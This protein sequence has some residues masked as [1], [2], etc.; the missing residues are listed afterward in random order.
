MRLRGADL[1]H[2]VGHTGGLRERAEPDAVD[3]RRKGL[4]ALDDGLN[5]VALPGA[6][7]GVRGGSRVV[8]V[9]ADV[10]GDAIDNVLG[11]WPWSQ[12]GTLVIAHSS[13]GPAHYCYALTDE[14]AF[15]L[16]VGSESE[17]GSRATIGWATATPG[18]PQAVEL[19]EKLY[20]VDASL[21][22]RRDMAAI[23]LSGGSLSVTN[24]AYDLDGSGSGT[25]EIRAYCIAA[26]NG[27]L[28]VAGYDS[29]SGGLEPAMVRHSLLGTDPS[30]AGGFDPDAYALIGAKG[31]AV[32]AMAPG[33]SILLL[34][35][36]TEL[37]RIT[38]TGKAVAGWQYGI[39]P[40]D[41]TIGLGC[42]NPL[43]LC[44]AAGQWYGLGQAGPW[45][46]D[47]QSVELLLPGR[48]RSWAR[49][50]SLELATVSYHPD[51]RRVLFGLC[52][53][54][55]DAPR[56]FWK[57]DL[58]RE[59]WDVSDRYA[60]EFHALGAIPFS[61][62]QAAAGPPEDLAQSFA[63]GHGDWGPGAISGTFTIGD[64]GAET[65]VWLR[66][67]SQSLVQALTLDPGIARFTIDS[68]VLNWEVCYVKLRHK[69]SGVWSD[70]TGEVEFYPRL[71]PP[72]PTV[73]YSYPS[74]RTL[75]VGNYAS[76]SLVQNLYADMGAYSKDWLD[77]ADGSNTDSLGTSTG[78]LTASIEEPALTGVESSEDNTLLVPGPV[79]GTTN[80]TAAQQDWSIDLSE[81][82]VRLLWAPNLWSHTIDFEYRV[83]GSGSGW[84]V[85]AT[86]VLPAYP[87]TLNTQLI[88]L[89]GLAASTQY[90]VRVR[91]S[92]SAY[93][94]STT[95]MYTKL[96]APTI[97]V[98]QGGGGT[99]DVDITVTVPASGD[100]MDVRVFS[101]S[102]SS[103]TPSYNQLHAAQSAGAN[104]YNSTA[105]T[106]GVKDRYFAAMYNSGWPTGWQYSDLVSDDID[107]PCA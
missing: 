94:S 93:V 52:E 45:R 36:E 86:V 46:S 91:I 85:G 30:S 15:A 6:R 14:M 104:V 38:G 96:E 2:I 11:G 17:S 34:A 18:R 35:K 105:G 4:G 67:A 60:S 99:P 26:Y 59:Q 72:Q 22:N 58:D 78:T 51:R 88:T 27:V 20:V 12:T 84:T 74:T 79:L 97:A 29:E 24:P 40:L 25:D 49:V 73:A 44:H 66:H 1:V 65:E 75:T 95:V 32:T 42:T 81:T 82:A 21:T 37:Y 101:A 103:G 54:G 100:G 39:S 50:D 102:N 83:T 70:W 33:G 64:A 63:F 69:K 89:S 23:A 61:A 5:M 3:P 87:A 41:N 106:C 43:A 68:I 76:N 19:F 28:F 71:R 92:G 53:V 10:G 107:D 13:A 56:K 90:D 47:G 9:F 8:Q 55:D 62:S 31:E 77:A 7:L 98:A 80:P 16:P 48:E 57:W